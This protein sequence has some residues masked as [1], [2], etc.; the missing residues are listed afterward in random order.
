MYAQD[1]HPL[2]WRVVAEPPGLGP[3]ALHLWRIPLHQPGADTVAADMRLLS[4]RQRERVERL[5][6][7]E[8]RRRYLRAQAGARRILALYLDI[9]P[10][11]VAF[12]YG[13]A[14]KPALRIDGKRIEFNLTTTGNLALLG[15]SA[16]HPLG[17]DCEL[18]SERLHL[19]DI[20]GRMFGAEI[21][22]TLAAMQPEARRRL[23][24]LHWTA[25]EARVKAD[26]RGLSRHREPDPT[27]LCVAHAF[28]GEI[29]AKVA[30]CAVARRELPPPHAW[31]A[32]E[33]V[34]R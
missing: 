19:L 23:F 25:L 8:H 33:L 11:D 4:E 27:D 16:V 9:S 13:P 1:P 24:H 30:L 22:A 29:D 12:R 3:K 28:A 21:K 6:V 20:A 18:E 32:L 31:E 2:D 17:V 34:G 10:A 14:G 5:R 7:P 15:V 26:G